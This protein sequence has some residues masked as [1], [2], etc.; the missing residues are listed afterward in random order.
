MNLAN[1]PE[2]QKDNSFDTHELGDRLDRGELFLCC[3]VEED[4]A[5]HRPLQYIKTNKLSPNINVRK[6]NG[7][8]SKAGN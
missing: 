5:I 7:H 1:S 3:F 6:Q 8:R 4:E 2:R